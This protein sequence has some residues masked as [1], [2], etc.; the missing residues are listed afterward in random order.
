MET[1][2]TFDT[3][4][5][6]AE[7]FL[8]SWN[9][10]AAD[11]AP[12]RSKKEE[13]S[14]DESDLDTDDAQDTD[15]SDVETDEEDVSED[16]SEDTEAEVEEAPARVAEDD[17]V[18]KVSVDGVE[19]DFKVSDL[20]RL[21][22]QELALRRQGEEA[23]ARR[24]SLDDE[25]VKIHTASNAL[26]ERAIERYKPYE[27]IDWAQA[28]ATLD[29]EDYKS[30][31]QVA[32]SAYQDLQFLSQGMEEFNSEQTKRR[33]A[34]LTEI[35]KK[36]LAELSDP[37]TG[38]SGFNESLYSEMRSYAISQG[39]PEHTMNTMVHSEPLRLIHKAMLWDRQQQAKASTSK[40]VKT[41][42][43]VIKS[44]VNV[45]ATRKASKASST[46]KSMARLKESGSVED[47][48]NAFLS[49]WQNDSND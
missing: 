35:A 46:D 48:A 6:G 29:P 20:K 37:K 43:Q 28:A 7:A 21:A 41:P 44:R 24:K 30:L 18:V 14:T 32:T 4:E 3:V 25:A 16:Q 36:S 39:I 23:S 42:T 26:I 15:L 13:N 22:G 10:D 1:N 45:E 47:A 38:I 19:T 27:N 8:K 5:D 49:R 11:E 34:E 40:V 2:N 31:K 33:T 9:T 12:I 17:A